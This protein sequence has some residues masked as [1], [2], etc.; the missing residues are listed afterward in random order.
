MYFLQVEVLQWLEKT[1]NIALV[2]SVAA[3]GWLALS[4]KKER[5]IN[6]TLTDKLTFV[7]TEM[8]RVMTS[9]GKTIEHFATEQSR[10]EDRVID[11]VDEVF[12]R[13]REKID[14]VKDIIAKAEY[15]K[16]EKGKS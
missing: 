15:H 16:D 4:L 5:A 7:S 11:K 10:V 3:C 1:D 9:M 14:T 13:L 2:L 12:D 8:T 6:V